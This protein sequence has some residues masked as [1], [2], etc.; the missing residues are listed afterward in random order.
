MKS[1]AALYGERLLD[2]ARKPRR[3]GLLTSPAIAGA[4]SN[5]LCGDE[6]RV[7]LRLH[8][9]RIQDFGFEAEA[10]AMTVAAASMLGDA[11]VAQTVGDLARL[12][13]DFGDWLNSNGD[14]QQVPAS[15]LC[16]GLDAFAELKQL[17]SRQRCALLPFEALAEAIQAVETST[18]NHDD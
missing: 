12:A 15:V 17:P 9:D 7:S 1:A 2:H 10:C 18:E 13:R 6:V 16:A 8:G 3:R 5:R 4:A 11:A 14:D